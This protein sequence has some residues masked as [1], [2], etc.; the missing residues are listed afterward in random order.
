MIIYPH[1]KELK[2]LYGQKCEAISTERERDSFIPPGVISPCS[3][4]L[5]M[6][7]GT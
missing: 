7:L 3:F 6:S 2:V 5:G 1:F 4:S